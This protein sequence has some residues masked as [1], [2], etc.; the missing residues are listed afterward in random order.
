MEQ[1]ETTAMTE[2]NIIETFE[3]ERVEECDGLTEIERV[4]NYV[5]IDFLG[6]GSYC[7]L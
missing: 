2:W 6:N 4:N 1:K 7:C 5:L 3:C